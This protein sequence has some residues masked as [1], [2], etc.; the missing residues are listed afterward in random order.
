MFKKLLAG[1]MTASIVLCAAMAPAYAEEPLQMTGGDTAETIIDSD[2]D[3]FDNAI[4]AFDVEADDEYIYVTEN[5]NGLRIYDRET[6]ALVNEGYDLKG[7]LKKARWISL[8]GSYVYVVNEGEDKIQVVNVS[9][10]AQPVLE[11]NVNARMP[12]KAIYLDKQ[13]SLL[14]VGIAA[15]GKETAGLRIYDV[16]GENAGKPSLKT[17][18]VI[19]ADTENECEGYG[20]PKAVRPVGDYLYILLDSKSGRGLCVY[21]LDAVLAGSQT[22]ND[23]QLLDFICTSPNYEGRD[24]GQGG[25]TTTANIMESIDLEVYG[26]YAFITIIHNYNPDKVGMIVVDTADKSNLKIHK[27]YAGAEDAWGLTGATFLEGNILYTGSYNKITPVRVSAYDVNLLADP[28]TAT[29]ED[30]EL[31]RVECTNTEYNKG[32]GY[33][34]TGITKVGDTLYAANCQSGLRIITVTGGPE[35]EPEPEPDPVLAVTAGGF[36]A[37]SSAVSSLTDGEITGS[38]TISN[39]TDAAKAPVVCWALYDADGRLA[40]IKL[41]DDVTINTGETHEYTDTLTVDTEEHTLYKLFAF[42]S[43]ASLNPIASDI[44]ALALQ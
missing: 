19:P 1:V 44:G 17:K 31:A 27:Q 11:P 9:N 3:A 41:A 30:A 43:L 25:T 42:E 14:Y 34:F 15:G 38:L 6:H 12:V 36:T 10:P 40:E 5:A 26:D 4:R 39:G 28:D 7:T 16:S 21:E 33:G 22:T 20:V 32:W 13:S 35:P 18:L 2:H 37:D 24:D 29:L 8:N 23:A